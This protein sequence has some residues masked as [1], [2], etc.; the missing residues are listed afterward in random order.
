MRCT[1]EISLALPIERRSQLGIAIISD[2]SWAC[3]DEVIE[4]QARSEGTLG[5]VSYALRQGKS[6]KYHHDTICQEYRQKF[7]PTHWGTSLIPEYTIPQSREILDIV[8]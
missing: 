4:I 5:Q 3:C 2:L 1:V 8:G 6:L 7:F